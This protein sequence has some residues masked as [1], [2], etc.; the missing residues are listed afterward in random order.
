[1]K[2][3]KV[4][5]ADEDPNSKIPLTHVILPENLAFVKGAEVSL[6]LGWELATSACPVSVVFRAPSEYSRD[7]HMEAQIPIRD[8][9]SGI[10]SDD[11]RDLFPEGTD[12]RDYMLRLFAAEMAKRL[13]LTISRTEQQLVVRLS[14]GNYTSSGSCLFSLVSPKFLSGTS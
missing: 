4:L 6:Q 2:E 1:M 12:P 5:P 14:F 11:L 9:P 13:L 3:M 8:L 7:V 10:S